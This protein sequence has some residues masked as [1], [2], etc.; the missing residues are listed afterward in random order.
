METFPALLALCEESP[1]VTSGFPSQSQIT[2]TF[3]F[4]LSAPEQ[5]VE[6]TIKTPVI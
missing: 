4:F 5:T 6:Q 3:D 1:P 2:Q